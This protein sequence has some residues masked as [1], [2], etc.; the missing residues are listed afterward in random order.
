MSQDGTAE[1]KPVSPY[2]IVLLPPKTHRRREVSATKHLLDQLS[3]LSAGDILYEVYAVPEPIQQG[4][5]AAKPTLSR[6]IWRVGDLRL[7]K[8]FASSSIGDRRL[9]FQHHIFENDLKSRP[10]WSGK[11]DKMLGAPFYQ[12]II[13]AGGAQDVSAVRHG[14]AK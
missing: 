7:L 12:E 1:A 11:A 2:A 5:G 4:A 9:R 13:E 8:P 10:D 3:E 14:Q 6:T